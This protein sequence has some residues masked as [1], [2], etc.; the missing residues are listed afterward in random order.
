MGLLTIT[1]KIENIQEDMRIIL[2]K[3]EKRQS[4]INEFQEVILRQLQRDK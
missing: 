1:N 3:L 2:N 4:N